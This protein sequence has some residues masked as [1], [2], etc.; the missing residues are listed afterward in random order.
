MEN[1]E[2][3]VLSCGLPSLQLLNL[4]SK[5]YNLQSSIE[6]SGGLPITDPSVGETLRPA[7]RQGGGVLNIEDF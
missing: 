7:A 4:Q 1:G 6:L 2:W 5:I 3:R